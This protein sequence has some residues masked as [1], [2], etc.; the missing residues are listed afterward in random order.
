MYANV[1]P[2][3]RIVSELW[4]DPLP[5]SMEIDGVFRNRHV[6]DYGEL[7]WLTGIEEQD[8]LQKLKLNLSRLAQADYATLSS[9]RGYGVVA[10]LDDLY[11]LSH[12]YYELLFSGDLGFDVVLVAGRSPH[13]GGLALWPNRFRGTGLELPQPVRDFVTAHADLTLGKADESFT[14]YD[15][16][17]PIILHNREQM[18]VDEMLTLFE[19]P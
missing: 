13:L 16:P 1:R 8:D 4:D 6:Y 14:V 3:A 12:Q 15:Q 9:N 2:G 18:T 19:L 10:R 5:S 17:M 7:T 11:P